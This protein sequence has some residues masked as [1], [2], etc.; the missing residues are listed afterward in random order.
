LPAFCYP[1]KKISS[2]NKR[3]PF[4]RLEEKIISISKEYNKSASLYKYPKAVYLKASVLDGGFS[5]F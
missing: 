5:N 4:K 3:K 1:D 2:S